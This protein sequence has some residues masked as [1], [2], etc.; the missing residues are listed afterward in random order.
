[1][2]VLIENFPFSSVIVPLTNDES[3]AV[4]T[5]LA[6]LTGDDFSSK[7]PPESLLWAKVVT[8]KSVKN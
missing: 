7:T 1:L 6:K 3:A 2:L 5:M 8:L 4:K